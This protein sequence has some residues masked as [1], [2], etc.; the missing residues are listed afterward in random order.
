MQITAGDGSFLRE[1][2]NPKKEN[3]SIHYSFAQAQVQT[4]KKTKPHKLKYSEIYYVLRGVGIM[5]IDREENVVREN[6]TVYIPA[7]AVQWVENIGKR[8]LDF[9]CI[10]DPAWE[11]GCEEVIIT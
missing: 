2:L 9:L 1:I 11:P 10:V 4:G 6:D 3:L 8:T 7:G 5:H